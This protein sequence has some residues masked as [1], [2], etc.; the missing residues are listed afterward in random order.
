LAPDGVNQV[1][2]FII[3]GSALLLALLSAILLGHPSPSGK[4]ADNFEKIVWAAGLQP[5]QYHPNRIVK[6]FS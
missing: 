6:P 2:T 1:M 3:P 5:V 4:T